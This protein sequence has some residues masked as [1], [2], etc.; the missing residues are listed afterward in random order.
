MRCVTVQAAREDGSTGPTRSIL[1]Q[2]SRMSGR[3]ENVHGTNP[4][5]NALAL[6]PLLC[7]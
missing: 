7:K 4:N 1:L 5:A 6:P 3:K 2:I